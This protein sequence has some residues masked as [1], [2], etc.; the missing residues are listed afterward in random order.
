MQVLVL[1]TLELS[2]ENLEISFL[3]KLKLAA[4]GV[5]LD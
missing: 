3:R 5:L 4:D 2:D 1:G